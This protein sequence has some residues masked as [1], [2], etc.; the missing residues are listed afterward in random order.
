M[1]GDDVRVTERGHN[2]DLAPD[3]GQV[4]LAV[5][6]VLADRLD[7]VLKEENRDW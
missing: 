3:P 4:M 2:L 6:L 5:D 1:Y 7:G